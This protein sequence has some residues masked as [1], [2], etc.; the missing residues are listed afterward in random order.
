MVPRYMH[1]PGCAVPCMGLLWAVVVH[2]GERTQCRR[3][4]EVVLC[5]CGHGYTLSLLV[6][7][8]GSQAFLRDADIGEVAGLWRKA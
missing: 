8:A 4:T 1:H 5:T 7:C 3:H 2:H 6:V